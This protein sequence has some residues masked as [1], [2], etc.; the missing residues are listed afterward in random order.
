[1]DEGQW[2]KAARQ[3]GAADETILLLLKAKGWNDSQARQAL[4]AHYEAELGI[5]APARKSGVAS[6]PLDGFLYVLFVGI[7]I[8]WVFAMLG[9][10]GEQVDDWLAASRAAFNRLDFRG[11]RDRSGLASAI[12]LTPLVMTLGG[13]LHRRLRLGVTAYSSGVRLWVISLALLIGVGVIIGFLIALLGSFLTGSPGADFLL[14]SG[15][16]IALIA[17]IVVYLV[18]WLRAKRPGH[19]LGPKLKAGF[20]AAAIGLAAALGLASLLRGGLPEV[21]AQTQRDGQRIA[22]LMEAAERVHLAFENPQALPKGVK[23]ARL[24]AMPESLAPDILSDRDLRRW[25]DPEGAPYTY[26]RTG[27]LSYELCAEF[28]VGWDEYQKRGL[29][30]PSAPWKFQAGESCIALTPDE[31]PDRSPYPSPVIN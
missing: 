6:N 19:L 25:K 10:W 12:V 13:L 15:F 28:E 4:A 17:A 24:K 9:L 2:I 3:A 26:R 5:E 30:A 1:M 23:A 11:P 22:D 18:L 21:V 7:L 29:E 27:D 20:A 14:N 16:A 31:D 8:A